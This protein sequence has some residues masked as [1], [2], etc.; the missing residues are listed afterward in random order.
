[1]NRCENRHEPKYKITYK[2]AKG[3]NY[4]PEWLVCE[5]CYDQRHFGSDD[6]V[7]SMETLV[8]KITA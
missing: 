7:Q 8:S 4:C 5:Q 1:M 3:Q 2:P 6:I